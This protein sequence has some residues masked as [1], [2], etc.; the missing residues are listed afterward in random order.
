MTVRHLRVGEVLLCR[1]Q[2][3]GR[4]LKK[5]ARRAGGM[6]LDRFTQGADIVRRDELV[7]PAQ[8]RGMAGIVHDCRIG[9]PVSANATDE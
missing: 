6:L 4:A 5:N 9:V 7:L 2:L 1:R 3:T 8:R